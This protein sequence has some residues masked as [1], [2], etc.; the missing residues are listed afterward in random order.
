M[1]FKY[2]QKWD[3][4]KPL[5]YKEKALPKKRQNCLDF[6]CYAPQKEDHKIIRT[7]LHQH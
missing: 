2:N 4:S 5:V 1:L 7:P 6:L 3:N